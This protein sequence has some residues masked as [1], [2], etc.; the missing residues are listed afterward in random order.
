MKVLVPYPEETVDVIRQIVGDAADVVGSGSSTEEMI[1]AGTDADIIASFRVPA[2]YIQQAP[3]LKMIQSLGAGIDRIEREAIAERGDM[4]VCNNHA[5]AEEVAEY[6]I[7]LLFAAAKHII[8]SDREMRAGDWGMRWGGPL[9]NVEIRDK[10]CLI[11]GLGHIGS[12]IAK[13]LRAFNM[14]LYAATRSG[15]SEHASL[16]DRVLCIDDIEPSLR[17]ADFVILS[18]PLTRD[19]AGLVNKDFLSMMK[20]TSIIVNISRGAIVDE[21]A[22]YEALKNGTIAAAGLDVWWDYPATWGG[23]GKLPSEKYPYHELDNVVISPHRAAYSE[24]I[25]RDQLQFVGE[26]ILRFIQ[27][28]QPLNQVD[29]HRGY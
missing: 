4:I 5:N 8:I 18:L 15:T 7:M 19:S 17:E 22:L 20:S 25:V 14:T 3:S 24:N 27:G 28:E 21:S 2:E 11:I 12:E 1:A 16:V 6:A 26:N 9:P 29:M 13:R 10:T 23:S